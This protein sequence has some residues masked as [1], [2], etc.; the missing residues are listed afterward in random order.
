MLSG[1]RVV[2]LSQNLAG[3]ICGQILGDLGAEVIKVEPP[4]GDP[5]RKWGPP[6]WGEE[7]PLF[8]S[9]NRNKRSI[10]VD[11]KSAEGRD[12]LGRLIDKADILV[13]SFRLGVIEKF[14]FGAEQVRSK[15]PELIYAS[16]TGFG[17]EG[18]LRETPGYDPLMQAYSGIMSITGHPGSP[19]ARVGGSVVDIG[20]G[21]LTAVGILAA[22][23]KRGQT[24]EGSHVESALLDTSIG[25]IGYHMMSYLASGNVPQRM[26]SGL[27]MLTPYEA[28]PA[29]DGDLMIG[30]GNDAIFQRLCQALDLPEIA[31]DNRFKE[32]PSRVAHR[33]ILLPALREATRRYTVAELRELLETH[34][35]PCSPI[36]DIA[37]V[38]ADPQ[39]EASGMFSRKPHPRIP[40]YRDASFP[41]KFDGERPTVR[42]A[43]PLAGEHTVEVLGELGFDE[44]EIDRLFEQGV[45]EGRV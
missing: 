21:I 31:A 18:P 27:E 5:A 35:V 29:K 22:L 44:I 16:I 14:G 34:R 17:S 13:Q 23:L 30:A 39:V 25:W 4:G 12:V 28:F 20:T 1:I 40:D 33:E 6:F 24:G 43:P 36:Q 38:V 9:G 37:Q 26:G 19:P 15:R 10:I 3:P 11:L 45:V 32:N 8:L 2:D 42:R 7:A 41:I